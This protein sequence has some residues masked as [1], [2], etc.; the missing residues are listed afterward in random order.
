MVWRRVLYNLMYRFGTP[1]WDTN[2]TPPAVVAVIEGGAAF[3][4]GRARVLGCGTGTNVIYLA[5][6]SWVV[7][8]VVE[9]MGKR[10]YARSEERKEKAQ[11]ISS[12]LRTTKV[13]IATS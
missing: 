8:G 4:P 12:S 5:Q 2:I 3:P 13:S 7:I 9:W 11:A 1:R 10:R 6:H